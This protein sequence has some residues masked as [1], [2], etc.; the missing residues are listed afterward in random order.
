MFLQSLPTDD[1][2][3]FLL[4]DNAIMRQEEIKKYV[5]DGYLVRT[6]SD[7]DTYEAKI[8]D[9]TRAEAAFSSGA[10][11]IST[12][13]FMEGKNTYGNDYRVVIPNAKVARANPVN[14]SRF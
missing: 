10:Q 7:I 1:F 4:M 12:D 2:A 6:R 8:N 14:M 13:F 11:L 5:S 3:A 9:Y